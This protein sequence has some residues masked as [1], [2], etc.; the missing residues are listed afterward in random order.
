MVEKMTRKIF[1]LPKLGIGYTRINSC[2]LDFS[3]KL[4]KIYEK[5]QLKADMPI[6]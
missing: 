3:T 5:L 2:F 6:G 4:M 1:L